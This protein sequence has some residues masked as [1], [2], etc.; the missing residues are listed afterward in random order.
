MS[1]WHYLSEYIPLWNAIGVVKW[2][3]KADTKDHKSHLVH[4][5]LSSH[6]TWPHSYFH[7]SGTVVWYFCWAWSSLYNQALLCQDTNVHFNTYCT[8]NNSGKR[9]DEGE[10]MNYKRTLTD[11]FWGAF[12]CLC[13]ELYQSL[14]SY[15]L[16]VLM[17]IQRCYFEIIY[18]T[19]MELIVLLEYTLEDQG[20]KM[21]LN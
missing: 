13:K 7:K 14:H 3:T 20:H 10:T 19:I 16:N 8:Q 2:I 1:S 18:C 6:V 17:M 12:V 15:W 21:D 9:M 5:A 11:K 4:S